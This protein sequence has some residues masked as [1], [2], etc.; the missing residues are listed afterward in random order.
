MNSVHLMQVLNAVGKGKT[1]LAFTVFFFSSFEK[2]ILA[3][4]DPVRQL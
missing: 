2:K 3:N 4:T 1:Q